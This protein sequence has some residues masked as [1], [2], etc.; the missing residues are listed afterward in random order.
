MNKPIPYLAWENGEAT[1]MVDGAPFL[2]LGGE[3]HNSSGSDLRYLEEKAWPGLRRLGG[4]CY[5]TPVY[6]EC[7]ESAPG[8][9]D[10]ALVDGVIEQA[11]RE[12][13]RL[14]L[15]WFGLWKNG[16]SEYIPG[17]MK[18]DP[19][20]FFLQGADGRLHESVSPFCEAAVERDRQAFTAL[21]AH[22][23]DTDGERTVI[24]VQ[25]ENEVGAWG[26]PRDCCPVSNEQFEAEIPAEMA[27]LY[28]KS[29]NWREAFGEDAEEY[30]M[31]WALSKAVGR[32]AASGAAQ[33]PLP[34]FMNC[35]A[36]GLPLKAGEIPSGGPLPRVHRIWRRFAP[37]IAVYGPDIYSPYYKEVA[38]DFAGANPLLV[39]ELS[40]DIHSASKAFYTVGGFNTLVFSPFGIDGLMTPLAEG[41]LLSQLN[42]D[43]R[44][45]SPEAGELLAE[46]YR[47][48]G[49]LW[50]AIRKAR[51]GG[52][53][54]AFLEKIA[55]DVTSADQ[56]YRF[57]CDGYRFRVSYGDGG[58]VNFMGQPG[59]RRED[60]PAGGG[61]VLRLAED[62]FLLC[63]LAFNVEFEAAEPGEQAFIRCKRELRFEGGATVPGRILNGDERNYTVIGSRP[64]ALELTLYRRER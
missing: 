45:P 58:F 57:E 28:D 8:K 47:I 62:R 42:T 7:M 17:W 32:I 43:Q 35:V 3:F 46:A 1:L 64:T 53:C 61:F 22:L 29:G 59:H 56:E 38:E 50:P 27:E 52:H 37:D 16:K 30:F 49:C 2:V 25:V 40:Q 21:M 44:V 54:F 41:D 10:F 15:L 18:D 24:M 60:G 13:V 11:R 9:Y 55:P 39:P 14:I 63:G 36:V 34:L 6:W 33:Y 48:L 23:R 31:A 4:N 19:Q 26:H 51:A 5:L 20:Y 12:G